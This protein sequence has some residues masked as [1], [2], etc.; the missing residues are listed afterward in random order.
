MKYS[1]F[2]LKISIHEYTICQ[3]KDKLCTYE[4]IVP[5]HSFKNGMAKISGMNPAR[6]GA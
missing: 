1:W 6:D 3:L 2:I 4:I 5:R